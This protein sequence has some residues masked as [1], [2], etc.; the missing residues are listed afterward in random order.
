L[1][2]FIVLHTEPTLGHQLRNAVE[3]FVDVLDIRR[4]L[5]G[6]F[7]TYFRFHILAYW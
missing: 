2:H 3:E 6:R 1:A 4:L 7:Q 5:N